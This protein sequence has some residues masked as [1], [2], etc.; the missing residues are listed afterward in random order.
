[1]SH[2][3]AEF[4]GVDI[5][6]L[7]LITCHLGNGSSM[8]AVKYG[9]SVD[10][11]MGLTP[12][13]G[14]LMGTRCGDLDPA[15]VLYLMRKEGLTVDQMDDLLNKKSGLLGVSGV[16]NDLREIMNADVHGNERAR[17]AI[18][19]FCSRITNYIGSYAAEMG[20]LD[21]VVF[22]GGI[23]ENSVEVRA[24]V[25]APLGFMGIHLDAAKNGSKE[26]E[27]VITTPDSNVKALVTPTNEELMIA[28]KT[29]AVVSLGAGVKR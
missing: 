15:V 7:K 27:K 4:L 21:G 5:K 18:D 3:A 20:G 19:I 26:K 2:R 13:G 6:E 16:S 28:M 9:I 14:L 22:T 1:V 23:G 8:A 17:L 25:L 29:R 11:S 12:L 24:Q 10:T